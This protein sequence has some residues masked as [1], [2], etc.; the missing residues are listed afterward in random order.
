MGRGCFCS[1]GLPRGVLALASQALS[2]TGTADFA[3][4][5]DGVVGSTVYQASVATERALLRSR[6]ST[7]DGV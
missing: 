4:S 2:P 7:R 1:C 3:V 5:R 6:F